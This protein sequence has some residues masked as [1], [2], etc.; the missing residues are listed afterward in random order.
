MAD[1]DDT[2]NVVLVTNAKNITDRIFSQ[3]G[4]FK[5]NGKLQG[6]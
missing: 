3:G 6:N 1:E 2:W 4:S 5:E